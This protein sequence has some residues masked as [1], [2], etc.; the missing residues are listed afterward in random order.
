MRMASHPAIALQSK[1]AIVR[2]TSRGERATSAKP[3]P[4]TTI[5]DR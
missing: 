2:G 1:A 5:Q 4:N 3:V